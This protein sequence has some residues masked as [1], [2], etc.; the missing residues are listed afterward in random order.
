MDNFRSIIVVFFLSLVFSLGMVY[1]H[2]SFGVSIHLFALNIFTFGFSGINPKLINLVIFIFPIVFGI[3]KYHNI[4]RLFVRVK[5]TFF[6][7]YNT[8][9]SVLLFIFFTFTILLILKEPV[10]GDYK[11]I[12]YYILYFLVSCFFSSW[13]YQ[14]LI[15]ISKKETSREEIEELTDPDIPIEAISQDLLS[16]KRF[17]EDLCQQIEKYKGGASIVYGLLG[18]WGEGKTSVLNLVK[19]KL[20]QNKEIIIIQFD[21]WYFNSEEILLKKFFETIYRTINEKYFLP[22]LT[23][24]LKRYRRLLTPI[25]KKYEIQFEILT[26]DES[27]EVTRKKLDEI[28]RKLNKK[29]VI[30]VDDLDR[31]E[32][33]EIKLMLK[34]VKLCTNFHKFC[35]LIPFDKQVISDVLQEEYQKGKDYLEKIVQQEIKL[36]KVEQI[37]LDS[38]FDV[39]F[40]RLFKNLDILQNEQDYTEFLQQFSQIYQSDIK[41][42]LNNIRKIKRLA[43]DLVLSLPL[44]RGEVNYFD[45]VVLQIIKIHFPNVYEDIYRNREYYYFT[46]WGP[47]RDQIALYFLDNLDRQKRINTYLESHLSKVEDNQE[48]LRN[49]LASI[50]PY[51]RNFVKNSNTFYDNESSIEFERKKG[52][53]HPK[54][55]EKYFLLAVPREVISDAQIDMLVNSLNESKEFAEVQQKFLEAVRDFKKDNMLFDFLD[56]LI[57][58]NKRINPETR[59]ALIKILYL[60]SSIFSETQPHFIGTEFT[61]ARDSLFVLANHFSDTNKIQE[62]LK[63]IIE[64]AVSDYFAITIVAFSSE[65]HNHII[66]NFSNV[67]LDELKETMSKRLRQK[68]ISER[69]NIFELEPAKFLRILIFWSDIG[70]EEGKLVNEYIFESFQAERRL[71]GSF[72]KNYLSEE[73]FKRYQGIKKFDYENLASFLDVDALYLIIYSTE[74]EKLYSSDDEK[75]AVEEFI[76]LYEKDKPGIRDVVENIFSSHPVKREIAY[77]RLDELWRVNKKSP[78]KVLDHISGLVLDEN[79]RDEEKAKLIVFLKHFKYYDPK[80]EILNFWLKHGDNSM[81]KFTKELVDYLSHEISCLDYVLDILFES[82]SKGNFRSNLVDTLFPVVRNQVLYLQTPNISEEQ[83][84]R[85]RALL[86]DYK[87]IEPAKEYIDEINDAIGGTTPQKKTKD[88]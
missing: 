39:R 82:K 27:I 4:A 35:Y 17:V 37:L 48:I 42:L 51:V 81:P 58:F 12:K 66:T 55:F 71:I 13:L 83:I 47:A 7:C 6:V 1:I 40:D 41:K 61:R 46:E 79:V 2:Y 73:P 25:I 57:V 50:F 60:N 85:I 72:L 52:I 88:A 29:I 74:L 53:A 49:L 28:L 3:W 67:H 75:L 38:Y 8:S 16:R 64:N 15:S 65:Q 14:S 56:K 34:L 78:K 31:L 77:R 22:A 33:D 68:Y 26:T 70:P 9:H 10:I 84:S 69:K 19:E 32:K 76:K 11:F 21:P 20:K 5:N 43:N 24:Y 87:D 23:R 44:V 18:E 36:P 62:I 54:C 30:F 63:D 45:F 59:E 86:K 80:T